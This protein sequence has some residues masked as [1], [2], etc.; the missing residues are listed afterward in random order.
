MP[1]LTLRYLFGL[2]GDTLIAGVVMAI[3]EGSFN[4]L[5]KYDRKIA[6]HISNQMLGNKHYTLIYGACRS[7][8]GSFTT[9]N[10]H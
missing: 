3:S 5:D 10:K 9:T 4:T 1:L 7:F 6:D 8:E 2:E